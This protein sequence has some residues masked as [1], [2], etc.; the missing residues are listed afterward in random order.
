MVV[1][2]DAWVFE[3]EGE[4]VGF[5]VVEDDAWVFE[6]GEVVGFLDVDVVVE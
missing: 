6:V 1:E 4:V 2:D 3:V 5:L